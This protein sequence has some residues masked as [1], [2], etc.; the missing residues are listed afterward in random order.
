MKRFVYLVGAL[1]IGLVTAGNALHSVSAQIEQV[2]PAFTNTRIGS[3]GLP[4][5]EANGSAEG[6]TFS[7]TEASAGKLH[8]VL[9]STEGV[10][11]Y[12][13]F[14]QMPEGLDADTANQQALA[15]ARDDVPS[16]GFGPTAADRT[17]SVVARLNSSSISRRAPGSLQ[18]PTSRTAATR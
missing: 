3:Y 9:N 11:V 2:D 5:L 12:V 8:V 13:D 1:L 16:E 15:M 10:A 18:P 17:Q 14:M 7:T 6:F 4:T